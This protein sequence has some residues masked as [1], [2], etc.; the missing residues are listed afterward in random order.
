MSIINEALK[1]AGEIKNTGIESPPTNLKK[2]AIQTPIIINKIQRYKLFYIAGI[3]MFS[4]FVILYSLK[5]NKTRAEESTLPAQNVII[6]EPK[7]I[8][9]IP[10]KAVASESPIT[11]QH[12]PDDQS[13]FNL[14]GIV[15]G[16]GAPMAIINDSV[17]IAGDMIN[18]SIIVEI[19]KDTVSLEKNGRQIKLRVK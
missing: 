8:Q 6:A 10:H 4:A 5:G 19:T 18:D 16:E 11:I 12:G 13:E 14:T 2:N 17:Y 9:E 15:L 1:K 3:I 7:I